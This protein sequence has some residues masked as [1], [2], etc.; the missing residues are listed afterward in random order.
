M[1]YVAVHSIMLYV[2]ILNRMAEI[3]LRNVGYAKEKNWT[4]VF[5][6]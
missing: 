1:Q 5:I 4:N 3:D 6:K 2:F